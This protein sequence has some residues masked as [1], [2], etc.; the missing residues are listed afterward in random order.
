MTLRPH[1]RQFVIARA[2]V[3]P[4]G[5]WAATPLVDGW[6]LSHQAD[7]ALALDARQPSRPRAVLG[8]RFRAGAGRGAGRFARLDWPRVTTDPAAL[9]GVF[10]GRAGDAVALGSSP[11]LVMLALTG[12]VPPHDAGDPLDHRGAIN[13]VPAPGTRWR[14]VRRLFCDQAFDLAAGAVVHADH[15]IR[16][17]AGFEAAVEAAAGELVAF[18][19]EL[20]DRTPGRIVLP[21]TAGL[22]SRTV[23]AAFLAAGIRFETTTQRYTGKADTDVRIAAAI[24]R[25]FG[26]RHQV[27]TLAEPADPAAG[28]RLAEHVSGAFLDWEI[29]HLFP[30]RAYRYLGEGDAMIVAGCFELGRQYYARQF[31]GLDF[32][33]AT[34]ADIWQRRSAAPGPAGLTGFLD[35]WRDWRGAHL[36]G[37]DWVNAFYLDQRLGA[38]RAEIE[39]GYDL[40]PMTALHPANSTPVLAALVTPEP[41]EQAEGRLQQA[42]IARLAPALAGFPLNPPTFVQRLRRLKRRLRARVAGR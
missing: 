37:L 5:T 32:A 2:P 20:A 7:L 26:L 40:M 10:H 6:V 30:G 23:A 21:L 4:D 42:V 29:T 38:W 39:H 35:D 14:A 19:R 34:G 1:R 27:V 13:F 28:A 12:E 17:L 8:H 33:A 41:A 3:A 11:A 18:A 24:S 9:L 22:D 25:R 31:G 16:P 36:D 15:G